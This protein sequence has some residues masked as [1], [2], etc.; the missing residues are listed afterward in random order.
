MSASAARHPAAILGTGSYTPDRVLTN[1]DLAHM[2]DTSNEWI[3][4]RTGIR[5]RRIAGAHEN[6]SDMASRAGAAAMRAAGIQPQDIDAVIVAT[7]TGDLPFPATACLVQEKLGLPRC[8]AF[9]LQ[10]ACTGFIYGLEVG[11]ALINAGVHRHI[12]LIGA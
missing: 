9:D 5:E 10:A 4:S 1:A 2:V 3:F 12:L 6:T 8:T 11:S 7:M